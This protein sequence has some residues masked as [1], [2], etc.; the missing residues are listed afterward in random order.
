MSYEKLGM[1]TMCHLICHL[2]S[3][4]EASSE[5]IHSMR[6]ASFLHKQRGSQKACVG[7]TLFNHFN[8]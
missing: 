3:F 5:S 2:E 1:D 8:V 6:S 4:G 7:Q